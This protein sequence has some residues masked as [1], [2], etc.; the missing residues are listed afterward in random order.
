[1]TDTRL[2]YLATPY[3]HFEG[4]I[5]DAFVNASRIAAK[6]VCQGVNVYAPIVHSHPI[7]VHGAMDALDH[8]LW[9]GV[10]AAFME[11]CDGM[12]VGCMAGWE[13]S[14]GVRFEI[15]WFRKAGKPIRYYDPETDTLASEM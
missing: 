13:S 12:I 8:A 15:D 3:T 11:R 1:M 7:A 6:L 4:G 9:M 10:D 2:W 14:K 5:D